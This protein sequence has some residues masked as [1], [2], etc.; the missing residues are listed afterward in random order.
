MG[1]NVCDRGIVARSSGQILREIIGSEGE[2][3]RRIECIKHE[4]RH[5]NLDHNPYRRHAMVDPA[6]LEKDEFLP[7]YRHRFFEF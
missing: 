7:E 5:W 1:I 6:S 3:L 2:K 4:G